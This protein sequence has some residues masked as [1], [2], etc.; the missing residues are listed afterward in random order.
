MGIDCSENC[1]A[2]DADADGVGDLCDVCPDTP[3]DVVVRP[4]GSPRSDLDGDCD[5]DLQDFALFQQDFF[6]PG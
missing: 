3:L 6:G 4:D 2:T 5:V 1:G